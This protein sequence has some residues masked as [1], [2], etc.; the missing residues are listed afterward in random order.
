M[1]KPISKASLLG[2]LRLLKSSLGAQERAQL[3]L[4]QLEDIVEELEDHQGEKAHSSFSLFEVPLEVSEC[5]ESMALFSDG[6]CRGNPGPG[7]WG[8]MGQNGEGEVIFE[9]SGVDVSTTNNRMELTGAIEA[10]KWAKEQTTR[11][12]KGPMVWLYTDSRYLTDGANLWIGG[13]KKRN[14]KKSG[15][16]VLE[17]EDLWR[18]IHG[19]M[20]QFKK[21]SFI[22]VK[23]HAGHPQN[24]YCDR[25]ANEALDRAGF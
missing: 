7:A 12:K 4:A 23:G 17:N 13:W 20:G 14:W 10:L 8:A 25:M 21:L 11:E 19:L 3:P 16:G 18:E 5:R 6:A 22:W 24:E 2:A 9:S 1:G 15:G